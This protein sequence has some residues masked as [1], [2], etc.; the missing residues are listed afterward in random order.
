MIFADRG[1]LDDRV[2]RGVCVADE[3]RCTADDEPAPPAMNDAL[4]ETNDDASLCCDCDCCSKLE[5]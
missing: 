4:G 1:R 3:T 2:E 5:S